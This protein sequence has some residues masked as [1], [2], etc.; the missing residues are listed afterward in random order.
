M[1]LD[2]FDGFNHSKPIFKPESFLRK[3]KKPESRTEEGLVCILVR[4]DKKPIP[5]N[6]Y[7]KCQSKWELLSYLNPSTLSR[8]SKGTIIKASILE[9]SIQNFRDSPDKTF[10]LGNI[11]YEAFSP[12]KFSAY[13]GEI[14]FDLHDL[15]DKNILTLQEDELK[16]MLQTP[17]NQNKIISVNRIYPRKEI[18]TEEELEEFTSMRL[19]IE[20]SSRI[21]ERI[22]FDHVS[23]PIIP[24]IIPPKRCFICQRYGHSS[25]SCRRKT[26][27]SNCA[28]DHFHTYC[29]VTNKDL[30]KCASCGNNHKSS[31]TLCN[32]YKQALKIS[33]QLQESRISQIQASREYAKLYN[34][35]NPTLNGPQRKLITPSLNL[36]P[37]Q[38]QSS[39]TL[40]FPTP[41][42]QFSSNSVP[43]QSASLG[44]F[45]PGQRSNRKKTEEDEEDQRRRKSRR[46]KLSTR[47][48]LHKT[49]T[50]TGIL[51][52]TGWINPDSSSEA[53]IDLDLTPCPRNSQTSPAAQVPGSNTLS[54]EDPESQSKD[55][56]SLIKRLFNEIT[57]WLTNKFTSLF[58]NSPIKKIVQNLISTLLGGY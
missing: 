7:N 50:Y 21:P 1:E 38:L 26:T 30:F 19:S 32:Y 40:S 44:S 15:E 37:S 51:N 25:L 23:M 17:G 3:R 16:D 52:G 36:D 55:I 24:Y 11:K 56:F 28:Q 8:N 46:S 14:T 4:T 29:T 2:L 27:C 35:E 31:S 47:T 5:F 58:G 13:H 9:A 10:I 22:F 54:G 41:E 57:K 43:C 42:T 12:K 48:P 6:F 33:A 45:P 34:R 49:K 39:P 18:T 20:F 53:E